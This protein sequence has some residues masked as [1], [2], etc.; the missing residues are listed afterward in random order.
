M[1]KELRAHDVSFF[2]ILTGSGRPFNLSSPSLLTLPSSPQWWAP[3]PFGSRRYCFS[4]LNPWLCSGFCC[5]SKKGRKI[6]ALARATVKMMAH[7]N[8]ENSINVNSSCFSLGWFQHF[9]VI[10]KDPNQYRFIDSEQ[11][12]NVYENVNVMEHANNTKYEWNCQKYTDL[13]FPLGNYT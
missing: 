12:A 10:C 3:P 2:I 5:N 4:R 9:R 7:P 1:R 6:P 8:F 13:S 11:H